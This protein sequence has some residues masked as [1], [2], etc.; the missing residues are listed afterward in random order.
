MIRYFVR[1]PVAAN[2]LMLLFVVLGIAVLSN[3][4]RETFPEFTADSVVITVPYPG[5]SAVDVDDEIC[6][7]LEDAVSGITGLVDFQCDSLDGR[8]SA[9]AELDE[10]GNLI[11]FFNDVFS[12]VSGINDFPSDAETASVEIAAQTDLV[13][14]IAISGISGKEGLVAYADELSDRLL[15][16][17]GV[18]EATVTGITDRELQVTFEEQ[19]LRR[20]GLS[21]QDLVDA[22]EARSF[23]QPLGSAAL[24]DSDLVLR[25]VGATRTIAELED[26]IIIENADGGI[27]RLSDLATISLVDS[28]ETRQSFIDG[29]QTAIISISKTADDDSIDV[30]DRVE[31]VINAELATY[32]DPFD[33]VVINNL[34]DLV[35]ERLTLITQNIAV[36]LVLVFVTM[37]LFFS[38]REA[39][40]ISA[41]LPVS[42]LGSFFVMSMLGITINMIT[43][44]ALLMAVGLIMDDSIVIAENI[45]KWRRKAPPLVAAAKGT[46]EVLPGVMSSFITTACVFGP[47][48]F[49]SGELGQILRFIPMVLLIT[50]AISL[51]EGF[52]ILPHHLSHSGGDDDQPPQQRP[53]DRALEWVREQVVLPVATALVKLRY[54][55]LGTVIAALIL[56]VGLVTSGTVKLIAFPSTEG[57]TVVARV[58]LTSG[59]ARERT[60]ATV[61]QLLDGLE[62]VD[63]DLTPGTADGAPLVE[64]VLVQYAVN[65]D[66]R[67]NG[68]HTATITVDLLE[69]SLRNVTADDMLAAWRAAAGPLPDV[70]QISFSQSEL[71]PGGLDLD[72]E[73]LGRD[74]AELEEA[75]GL[76]LGD[77]LARE[78]V[79]EAF[80]D[81]YGG[82]E[83]VQIALNEY[84]YSIGL[85]PQALSAQL[86]TAFEGSETDNFRQGASTRTVRVQLADTIASVTELER[87]P[88]VLPGG[89]Q[90]SLS[91]IADLT[92]SASYPNVTRKN[93]QAVARIQGKIDRSVTTST[94]I[95]GV[96]LNELAPKLATTYPDIEVKIGGATEEQQESQKSMATYLSIGL[97]GVYMVLAFQFRSYSLPVVVMLSI[98]F[99]L[100]GTILGHLALGMDLS[101]PSLVGF[102]SLA[103]IVVN[104]AILFLTFFQTNL[105]GDDYVSASLD[106]VRDRFRPILLSSATTFVGLLPIIFDTSPQVQTLVPLVVAV[107]FGLLAAMVLVVLVLPSVMSIY[108]DMFSV[109]HWMGQFDDQDQ[110]RS[111]DVKTTEARTP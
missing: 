82:R 100:I 48:M 103:G 78:D 101:M 79:T 108:F 60:V 36:G 10:G 12:A 104:N 87:F 21:S 61:E 92:A 109:R 63:A 9:T 102:A 86:R 75:A 30:F 80:Q 65:A 106:A 90:T 17:P 54:L 105:R 47:L 41:A 29:A 89:A 4:E 77:L 70:V 25:Y 73:L 93:G 6:A 23:R 72:V 71:G 68:S 62:A 28:D 107:A 57:D 67:D 50:L 39:L 37:W 35:S 15:M 59:I 8:A 66:V 81:F 45:A 5:A 111:E 98:P 7:P 24:E 2:I 74:L 26:L 20:F 27:V 38:L 69:S 13:A 14:L 19:D 97:V 42:F 34:A 53:A 96:I 64:R 43:L 11:Q 31:D 33:I 55:T 99:A 1:H 32:P 91:T 18:A 95:S 40:W 76:L 46:M 44:I 52:L 22:I 83:E 94:A 56:C 16:V 110:Q 85:T 58:A 49:I 3:L 84:G 88:I 51:I